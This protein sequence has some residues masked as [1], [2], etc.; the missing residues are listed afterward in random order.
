MGNFHFLQIRWPELYE[1]AAKAEISVH[2]ETEITAI[3][4]RCFGEL[5]VRIL[6]QAKGLRLP[7]NG[8]QFENLKCLEEMAV[9]DREVLRKLH[10]LRISGNKAAHAGQ[11]NR[12]K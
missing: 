5:V 7:P 2:A 8:S 12:V 4:L 1:Q 9:V 6:F 10:A 11:G 3:R